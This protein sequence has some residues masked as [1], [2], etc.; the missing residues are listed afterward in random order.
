LL[1]IEETEALIAQPVLTEADC[2]AIIH[3]AGDE[4][5]TIG[6][7]ALL[8]AKMG[9]P[10]AARFKRLDKA[11][12]AL[13]ADV[14]AVFPDAQY[15]TA[16]GGFN[17]MLGSPHDAKGINPQAELLALSGHASIGDGDF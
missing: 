11:L 4:Y 3:G 9:D 15:Y 10:I 2:L 6:A 17:L 12:I 8:W 13:L 7:E 16:S 1:T 14:R 5:G